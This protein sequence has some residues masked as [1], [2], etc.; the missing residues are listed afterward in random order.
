VPPVDTVPPIGAVQ[1]VDQDGD[2]ALAVRQ[3]LAR[4][5]QAQVGDGPQEVPGADVGPALPGRDRGF[6][7]RPQGGLGSLVEV[8]GQG[9][10]RRVAG[11][12]G[13]RQPLLGR[14]ELGVPVQPPGE[15]LSWLVRRR[16]RGGRVGA[17]VYLAL[18]HGLD[19]VRAL[20]EVPVQ[21]SDADTGP[22]GDLLRG[23]VHP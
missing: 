16:Q 8:A 18:K 9:R 20:R 7:Q 11:V 14:E 2:H 19:Q 12:K 3:P 6:Q 1:P 15:R 23:R 13:L 17:G 22:V 4:R 21:G 5:G 10:E